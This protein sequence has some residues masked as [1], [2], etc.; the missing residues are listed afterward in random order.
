M[1]NAGEGTVGVDPGGPEY[2]GISRLFGPA[3]N[4]SRSATR[5]GFELAASGP[6]TLEVFD[7]AGRLAR[8]L[9]PGRTYE[10]GPH[11]LVWDGADDSGH[12]VAGGIYYVRLRSG[13]I[14]SV[15][16]IILSR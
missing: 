11:A 4:P 9:S 12:A 15:Q 16:K 10:A 1:L 5:I 7:T 14:R 8:V 6:V 13:A 2:P 3:P